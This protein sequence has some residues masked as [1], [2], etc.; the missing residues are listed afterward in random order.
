MVNFNVLV[1]GGETSRIYHF[2]FIVLTDHAKPETSESHP[3]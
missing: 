1:L 3:W 2:K